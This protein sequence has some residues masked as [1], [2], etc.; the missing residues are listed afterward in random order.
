VVI[1]FCS[2]LC[3]PDKVII[4]LIRLICDIIQHLFMIDRPSLVAQFL[5]YSTDFEDEFN[6]FV[7][8]E[9]IDSCHRG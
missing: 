1:C 3:Q 9:L 7:L 4:S 8:N 5:A 2:F 6:D